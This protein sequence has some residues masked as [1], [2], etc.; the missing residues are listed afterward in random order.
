MAVINDNL[1]L[2]EATGYLTYPAKALSINGLSCLSL[3]G[4]KL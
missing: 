1:S 4:Q 2:R 3:P